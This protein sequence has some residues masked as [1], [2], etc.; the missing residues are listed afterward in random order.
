M[1]NLQSDQYEC[2][3]SLALDCAL[4]VKLTACM[5]F[6]N[7]VFVYIIFIATHSHIHILILDQF[8]FLHAWNFH[9]F[10]HI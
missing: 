5:V 4:H 2:V 1:S 6:I 10:A 7:S 9:F 3:F 8:I